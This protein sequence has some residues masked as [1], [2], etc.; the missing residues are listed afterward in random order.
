MSKSIVLCSGWM[1]SGKDA[2]GKH[3]CRYYG[4]RQYAFAD[5]LKDE[6]SKIYNISRDLLDTQQG[7]MSI[8]RKTGGRPIQNK[9]LAF[10]LHFTKNTTTVR[11][12]L[13]EHGQKRRMVNVNYWVD[14]V[15]KKI[16]ND[17]CHRAVI[18]D[19]RYV[20]EFDAFNCLQNTYQIHTWRINRWS[21]PPLLNVSETSLDDFPKFTLCI[22][23]KSD[24]QEF[25]RKIDY[26]VFTIWY[27]L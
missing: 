27:S 20:N 13:I 25:M 19:W 22:E 12:I 6:V 18:T 23:N 5:A 8:V 16:L 1:G 11:N 7:K 17:G 15:K 4:F 2:V 21:E 14:I 26:N 10:L 3:L 9:F 24:I